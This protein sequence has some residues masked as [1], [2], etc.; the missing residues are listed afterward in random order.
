MFLG[1]NQFL[2][3]KLTVPVFF[4][5]CVCVCY[6]QTSDKASSY[7][8]EPW[9]S[10]EDQGPLPH[11]W[12]PKSPGL[13][14]AAPPPAPLSFAPVFGDYVVLQQAP[15]QVGKWGS[16]LHGP[17]IHHPKLDNFWWDKPSIHMGEWW[18]CV[19]HIFELD[20]SFIIWV[21]VSNNYQIIKHCLFFQDLS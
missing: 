17:P 1:S 21:W 6:Q 20:E 2:L 19:T 5:G 16:K 11:F 3:C 10:G 13:A 4:F 14:W 8:W 7:L 12:S 9:F 18:H 15:A